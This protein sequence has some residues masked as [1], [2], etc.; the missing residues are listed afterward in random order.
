MS[1][2]TKQIVFF[3][4]IAI[5]AQKQVKA[6]ETSYFT[7]LEEK[8][9]IN[10]SSG[11]PEGELSAIF[12]YALPNEIL[13]P[14]HLRF[15]KCTGLTEDLKK[16][17]HTKCRPITHGHVNIN[18]FIKANDSRRL[19]AMFWEVII[20]YSSYKITLFTLDK[21]RAWFSGL[22]KTWKYFKNTG[23]VSGWV[24][25]LGVLGVADQSLSKL[26][27]M[28]GGSHIFWNIK[29]PTFD[30]TTCDEKE[31]KNLPLDQVNGHTNN[32]IV[33]IPDYDE[34]EDQFKKI[35]KSTFTYRI[36]Q[37]PSSDCATCFELQAEGIA[38]VLPNAIPNFKP[39]FSPMGN[40]TPK[41]KPLTNPSSP[42][43]SN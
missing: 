3:S 43:V 42:L 19:D 14:Q 22:T 20:A 38:D 23:T 34:F 31:C 13:S 10:F 37:K 6:S 8:D 9:F 12:S 25:S 18:Q 7:L 4:F 2:L 16:N 1:W 35:L 26:I 39:S 15:E 33:L 11:A 28:A 27:E 21:M 5:F 40:Y 17:E 29:N 36:K 32:L 24:V 41:N 30:D